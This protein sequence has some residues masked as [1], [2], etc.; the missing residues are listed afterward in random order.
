MSAFIDILAAGLIL[1]GSALVFIAA[2]GVVRMEDVFTRMHASTKAGTLGLGL[3][4]TAFLIGSAEASWSAKAF[5]V[6][7]FMLTTA[8]VGAHI[9]GRSV[10]RHM[11]E[12]ERARCAPNQKPEE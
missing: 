3:I 11:T 12:E 4:V 1:A 7:I 5:A 10:H 8:P 2:L 6:L 9:V